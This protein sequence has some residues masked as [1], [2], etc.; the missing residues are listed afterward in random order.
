MH[1]HPAE[2]GASK[3]TQQREEAATSMGIEVAAFRYAE[4]LAAHPRL[5][6]TRP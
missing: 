6:L 1:K 5:P 2:S 4:S 3:A